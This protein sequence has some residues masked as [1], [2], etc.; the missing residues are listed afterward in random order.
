MM[1]RHHIFF[2]GK[3]ILFLDIMLRTG[4]TKR[5]RTPHATI[6]FCAV[7]GIIVL[8]IGVSQ[9][10]AR[11]QQWVE[12]SFAP[13]TGIGN[14][15]LD[16]PLYSGN[17]PGYG[18]NAE[19]RV[20]PL[21]VG[22]S[23]PAYC[24]PSVMLCV[25]GNSHADMLRIGSGIFIDNVSLMA[26]GGSSLYGVYGESSAAG[27]AGVYGET[28]MDSGAGV[29]GDGSGFTKGIG[30][31]GFASGP[32]GAGIYGVNPL[33]DAAHFTGNV[34]VKNDPNGL[35][36][37]YGKLSVD[38]NTQVQGPAGFTV[39]DADPSTKV[40]LNLQTLTIQGT[41]FI[42]TTVNA[43]SVQ[44]SALADPAN[45]EGF[46]TIILSSKDAI[47]AGCTGG[48]IAG[49]ATAQWNIGPVSTG[50]TGFLDDTTVVR[51]YIAQYKDSSGNLHDFHPATAANLKYQECTADG[52]AP[53]GAF[54]ITNDILPAAPAEFRLTVF[55]KD[56]IDHMT[57]APTSAPIAQLGIQM[58]GTIHENDF[59]VTPYH[60]SQWYLVYWDFSTNKCS[61]PGCTYTCQIFYGDVNVTGALDSGELPAST[62]GNIVPGKNYFL[63]FQDK[64]S[65]GKT[66]MTLRA[67]NADVNGKACSDSSIYAELIPRAN[68]T[69][70]PAGTQ[71]IPP[72]TE[73]T[74]TFTS[75][76]VI[77]LLGTNTYSWNFGDGSAICDS[78]PANLP[79]CGSAQGGTVERP[80]HTYPSGVSSSY[81]VSLRVF[82]NG[83]YSVPAIHEVY[84]GCPVGAGYTCCTDN[85]LGSEYPGGSAGCN[86]LNAPIRYCRTQC[87]VGG[88]GCPGG[89]CQ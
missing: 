87:P 88:S 37:F 21:T 66:K 38:N 8:G 65:T 50:G 3:Q 81:F 29:S 30:V 7:V 83:E 61:A 84:A 77:G 25:H 28:T 67:C 72:G 78:D 60:T 49:G 46:K 9:Y 54:S 33:G 80:I 13:P 69:I 89:I 73:H 43:P 68:F 27:G 31:F 6:V 16:D 32:G 74:F 75:T 23:D 82:S 40:P 41:N 85:T 59:T 45:K 58:A 44:D 79:A 42:T 10:V 55:Y 12:P 39:G 1:G 57:C 4:I 56:Y 24:D 19:A 36:T 22:T 70:A 20:G 5:L 2:G 48:Q 63:Y 53:L 71:S 62:C 14:Q 47:C 51:G 34:A 86:G 15:E 11:A 17:N 64:I 52:S 26:I 76:A 18:G 35:N